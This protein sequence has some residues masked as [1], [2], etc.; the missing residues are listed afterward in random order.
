MLPSMSVCM[1]A[2]WKK[3]Q[4]IKITLGTKLFCALLS[5]LIFPVMVFSKAI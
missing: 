2:G 3:K 4:C 5:V 1:Y